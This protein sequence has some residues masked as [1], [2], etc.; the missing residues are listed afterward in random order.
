MDISVDDGP[1][2]LPVTP[3][4]DHH[5]RSRTSST[6]SM[7][8][9]SPLFPSF[10]TPQR[11]YVVPSD[12]ESEAEEHDINLDH[13]A[14]ED[15]F[16]RVKKMERSILRYRTKYT[17]LTNAYKELEKE[18][19]KMKVRREKSSRAI[20]RIPTCKL[21]GIGTLKIFTR[22]Y[23]IDISLTIRGRK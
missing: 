7:A 9:E 23:N 2:Q 10:Q 11:Q 13:V 14:K 8:S 4:Q 1:A 16:Y 5:S 12:I 3:I 18:R 17:Q 15:L 19:E 6:S 21:I 20:T 22:R